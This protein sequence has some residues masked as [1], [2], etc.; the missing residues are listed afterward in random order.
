[1]E[2]LARGELSMEQAI[3]LLVDIAQISNL[4]GLG[5]AEH[6]PWDA[7]NLKDMLARLPFICAQASSHDVL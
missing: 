5:M 3:S 2:N 1:L 6:L 4:V 7:I